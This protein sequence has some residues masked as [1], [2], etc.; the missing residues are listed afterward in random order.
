LRRHDPELGGPRHERRSNQARGDRAK[1]ASDE[2]AAWYAKLDGQR[3]SNA[4]VSAFFA[5]RADSVNDAAYTRIEGLTTSVRAL[6]DDPR[7][8]AIAQAGRPAT[9]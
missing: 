8:R 5:W 3:V 7:L 4:E 6:A 9:A 2:A 1:R